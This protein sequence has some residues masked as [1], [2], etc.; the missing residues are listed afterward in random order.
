MLKNKHILLGITGSI[1]AFK[2]L[3]LIRILKKEKACLDVVLTENAT[4]FVTSLAI[5]TLLGKKTYSSM[6]EPENLEKPLHLILAKTDLLIIAPA[7]ANFIAKCANGL[8][9]DLLS[10]LVLASKNLKL[11]VPAMHENMYNN[12][13]TQKNI[14]TLKKTGVVFMEPEIGDL[15]CGDHGKGRFPEVLKIAAKI[16]NFL[17]IKKKSLI[18]KSS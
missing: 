1:A 17:L 3:E 18:K 13:L 5:E 6:W 14:E 7:T 8:A 10:S 9:D 12:P 4:R 15:A 2:T 16:K 11:F